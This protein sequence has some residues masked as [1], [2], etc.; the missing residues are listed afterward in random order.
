MLET[1]EAEG[2]GVGLPAAE[3]EKGG[4][5][6]MILSV[7]LALWS[8]AQNPP[9]LLVQPHALACRQP[10]CR[11]LRPFPA[12]FPASWLLCALPAAW[13]SLYTPAP[14]SSFEACILC[15]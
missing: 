9:L 7:S 15:V 5:L 13:T 14:S 1:P 11:P 3:A 12:A 10:L 8:P 2:G 4:H 6:G